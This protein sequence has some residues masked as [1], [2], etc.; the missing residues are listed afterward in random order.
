MAHTQTVSPPK[1]Q[2][3]NINPLTYT[4]NPYPDGFKSTGRG[5][6]PFRLQANLAPTRQSGPEYGPGFQL[7]Q[8]KLL[9]CSL[10]SRQR[11]Q[12]HAVFPAVAI[13]H[14][15]AT[16]IISLQMSGG[17]RGWNP[18]PWT[19][20]VPASFRTVSVKAPVAANWGI[21]TVGKKESKPR[22]PRKNSTPQA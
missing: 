2:K 12:T 3:I 8:L 11:I 13:P 4:L 10:F 19:G 16:G 5:V 7:R 17:L 18:W 20:F 15:A 14:M 22:A 6:N 21:D 9:R 1:P